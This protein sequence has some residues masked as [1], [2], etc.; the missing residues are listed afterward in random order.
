MKSQKGITLTSLVIYIMLVLLIVG[1]LAVITANY[2]GGIKEIKNEGTNNSEIDK[3]NVYFLKEVKKQENKVEKISENEIV[4]K[5]GNKYTFKKNNAIY[6]NDNIKIADDIESCRF[7]SELVNGKTVVTVTIKA[8]YS[9][10]RTIEYVLNNQNN[11]SQYED[12]NDY[13]N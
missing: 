4:F 10:E 13:I 9:E 2:Q 8:Q 1:M 5:G 12:E 11:N 6:L 7:S 3:F